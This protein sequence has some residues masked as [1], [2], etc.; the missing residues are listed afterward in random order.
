MWEGRRV[1][2]AGVGVSRVWTIGSDI[3]LYN[4]ILRGIKGFW[5][6]VKDGGW[7]ARCENRK[8]FDYS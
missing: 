7:K 1:C 2:D 4:P 6:K 3:A 5:L 8:Q